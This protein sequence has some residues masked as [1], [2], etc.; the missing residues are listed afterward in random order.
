MR[1][2]LILGCAG[3]G[4]S[5]MAAALGAKLGIPVVHLDEHYWRPGW[6]EVPPEEWPGKVAALVEAPAW[7]MDGNYLGT[8]PARLA[9][10]DTAI[11]LDRHRLVCLWRVIRRWWHFRGRTRPEL[12][13]GCLEK[14]DWEFVQWI[15]NY[16]RKVRSAV[17][18]Q[19]QEKSAA[20]FVVVLR[21]DREI[22][23]FLA[24]LDVASQPPSLLSAD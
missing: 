16:P 22:A 14:I 21:S 8:L 11:F 6:V 1:R 7:V 10:C 4:K 24:G 17:Q 15:W 19:L 2:V 13:E 20:K 18:A 9:A 3:T 12:P 5:T 23:E